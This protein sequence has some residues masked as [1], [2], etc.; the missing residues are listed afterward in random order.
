LSRRSGST[1]ASRR[2]PSSAFSRPVD[3][4]EPSSVV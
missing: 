4:R 1:M 2:S 3:R